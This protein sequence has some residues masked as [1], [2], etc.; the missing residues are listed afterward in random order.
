MSQV[1]LAEPVDLTFP[2]ILDQVDMVD[3][4]LEYMYLE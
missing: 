3:L 1:L 2:N 4:L